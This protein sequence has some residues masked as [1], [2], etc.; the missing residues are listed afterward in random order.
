LAKKH[1]NKVLHANNADLLTKDLALALQEQKNILSNPRKGSVMTAYDVLPVMLE[2]KVLSVAVAKH[3]EIETKRRPMIQI[4]DDIVA[5]SD[6]RDNG[7]YA[8]G[9]KDTLEWT[10][11]LFAH[12]E[13][14]D[15]MQMEM[16]EIRTP[17]GFRD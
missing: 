2:V 8:A 13:V 7:N 15:I 1:G 14:Q 10:R 16:T 12:P 11:A 17:K 5:K 9:I 4:L 6:E 3:L